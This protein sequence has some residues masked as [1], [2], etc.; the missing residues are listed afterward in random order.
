[1]VDLCHTESPP[2]D[3]TKFISAACFVVSLAS[4]HHRRSF[5]FGSHPLNSLSLQLS[6]SL[7]PP[8]F[9]HHLSAAKPSEI[10]GITGFFVLKSACAVQ[11]LIHLKNS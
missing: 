7:F 8:F 5:L 11:R 10:R 6:Y 3:W 9:S 2:L 4:V 1:M